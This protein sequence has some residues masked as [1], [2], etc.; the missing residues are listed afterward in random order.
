MSGNKAVGL[1]VKALTF[2]VFGTITD[3]RGTLIREG[4]EFGARK[5]LTVDWAQFADAWRSGYAPAMRRVNEGE[6]AWKNIDGLHRMI[7]EDLLQRFGITGLEEADKE[8][9]NRVWH[10]LDPWPDVRSGLA[11]LRGHFLVAPLSNGNVSLL[12]D[13]ARHAGLHWDCVL[14]AE[15]AKRYKTDPAPYLYAAELLGL[16]PGQIMMVAAHNTD[17]D[18]ARSVGF[19]TAF[20]LRSREFGPGQSTDLAPNSGVNIVASDLNDLAELLIR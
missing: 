2:D 12:V 11:R 5:Q 4:R 13:L 16:H 10:R 19:R 20:V 7:L 14:S 9:L 6:I 18:A 15:L 3:W 1:R 17:L 8:H